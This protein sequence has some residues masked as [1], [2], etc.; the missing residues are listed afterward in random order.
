MGNRYHHI[1][2]DLRRLIAAGTWPV[3]E[4]LPAEQELA[5]R[6][7]VSTPT[8]RNALEVLQS[9]GLVEKR[10]GAGNFVR[11]PGQRLTYASERSA[12]AAVS[13]GLSVSHDRNTV[14]ADGRLALL[15][16]VRVG[17]P[18]TEYAFIG[19]QGASPRSLARVYVPYA[20]ARLGAV[21][22]S[23]VSPWGDDVRDL[24]MAAG[25]RAAATT[26]RVTARFPTG[27]EAQLLHITRRSP[28][29]A[30]ERVSTDSGGRVVEGALLVLPGDRSE[31]LH[32]G[33]SA[34]DELEAT[35]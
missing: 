12:N 16:A 10:H 28:V 2:D 33:C 8:L 17:S 23:E 11:R 13:V 29:L 22:R 32:T 1:A 6:Y 7:R 18:L 25:V 14:K 15:L 34:A 21:D 30:V 20:V 3:G 35:G 4:R 5:A 19:H 24:L 9:E 31:I 27:D 26:E